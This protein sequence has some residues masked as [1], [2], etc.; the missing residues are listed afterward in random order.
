MQAGRSV[1]ATQARVKKRTD[2]A[3]SGAPSSVRQVVGF[4]VL[5]WPDRAG[6]GVKAFPETAKRELTD[7]R[8]SLAVVLTRL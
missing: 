5:G 3:S 7:L 8:H 1:L 4:R 6:L 2:P